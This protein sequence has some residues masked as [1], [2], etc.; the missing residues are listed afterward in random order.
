MIC[1][2]GMV[3]QQCGP[4]CPQTCDTDEHLD[5]FGGCVEGCFCPDGLV[6][7]NGKCIT[8][9]NCE[10]MYINIYWVLFW[11]SIFINGSIILYP[12]G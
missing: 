1:S 4:V 6:L 7:S 3:Y 5:C 9:N 12:E 8:R 11:F 2:E 10:G